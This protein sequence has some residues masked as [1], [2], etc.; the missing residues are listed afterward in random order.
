[1]DEL[2]GLFIGWAIPFVVCLDDDVEGKRSCL[3][4]R[5]EWGLPD[6]QIFSL[7]DLH[8]SLAGKQVEGLLSDAERETI[9]EHYGVTKLKKGQIGL[10]F[11]EVLASG[12]PF[13]VSKETAERVIAFDQMVKAGLEQSSTLD[14]QP[15]P[16]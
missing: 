5:A 13:D 15:K 12:K 16:A 2:I 10:Y 1:M 6:S 3:R 9:C 11:S 14:P 4:Y 8:E 7:G